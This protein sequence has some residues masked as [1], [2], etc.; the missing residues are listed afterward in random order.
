MELGL[1]RNGHIYN[2][3]EEGSTNLS[4]FTNRKC[5]KGNGGGQSFDS[6]H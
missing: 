6:E 2:I 5:E 3:L 4:K 1:L